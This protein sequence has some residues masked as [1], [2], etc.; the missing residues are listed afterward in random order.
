[1][2]IELKNIFELFAHEG[3]SFRENRMAA[4]IFMIHTVFKPQNMT[5]TTISSKNLTTEFLRIYRNFKK[6]LKELP[7]IF[8]IN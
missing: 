4:D 6:I 5:G 7:N 8:T 3:H 1:M 2:N